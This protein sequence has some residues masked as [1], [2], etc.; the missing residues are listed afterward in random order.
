MC[1]TRYSLCQSPRSSQLFSPSG[2]LWTTAC[3]F[4]TDSFV[5]FQTHSVY[6]FRGRHNIGYW[7]CFQISV[8]QRLRITNNDLGEQCC[9]RFPGS[10]KIQSRAAILFRTQTS[11]LQGE[12][13]TAIVFSEWFHFSLTFSLFSLSHFTGYCLLWGKKATEW[14]IMGGEK[15]RGM[16]DKE[17]CI[18][19]KD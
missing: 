17:R 7:T 8:W 14:A 3:M 12:K 16:K 10:T 2:Q 1:A 4:F 19:K 13:T 18:K 11:T 9:P 5:Y 15:P 6:I